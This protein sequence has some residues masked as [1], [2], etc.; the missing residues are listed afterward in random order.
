MVP[1]IYS[2]A[3]ND[4][5]SEIDIASGWGG[6]DGAKKVLEKQWDTFIT[7][8]DFSYLASIG[9]NTLRVP[10]GY[11]SLG[12][13]FTKGSIYEKVGSVYENS[14]PRVMRTLEWAGKYGIGVMIDLHGAYGSQNGTISA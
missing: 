8:K 10:I 6:T 9:I 5:I 1:S 7:E 3:A 2:C 4:K 14:W 13:D 11:W 12:P